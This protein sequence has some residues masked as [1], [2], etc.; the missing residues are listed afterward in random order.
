MNQNRTD[1]ARKSS[2]STSFQLMHVKTS[3]GFVFRTMKGSDWAMNHGVLGRISEIRVRVQE[4]EATAEKRKK[5]EWK[6][7]WIRVVTPFIHVLGRVDPK[8]GP[9]S[10][11]SQPLIRIHQIRGYGLGFLFFCFLSVSWCFLLYTPLILANWTFCM[12]KNFTKNSKCFTA[13]FYYF[14]LVFCAI[15]HEETE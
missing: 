9:L 12:Q 6:N 2:R 5:K 14:F 13:W 15:S 1:S 8:P 10:S 4:H 7:E 3:N 11:H